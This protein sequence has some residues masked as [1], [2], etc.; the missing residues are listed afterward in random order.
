MSS[1]EDRLIAA[2]TEGT[3]PL[4]TG[5]SAKLIKDLRLEVES[6]SKRVETLT[7]RRDD[8]SLL[9]D[10]ITRLEARMDAAS[11]AFSELRAEVRTPDV[12]TQDGSET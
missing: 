10:R 11:K 2:A 8:V 4:S 9:A 7:L 1:E 5:L 3:V 12:P 6:L